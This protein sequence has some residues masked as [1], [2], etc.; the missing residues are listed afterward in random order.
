MSSWQFKTATETTAHLEHAGH[1]LPEYKA[2]ISN[3][4]IVESH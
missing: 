4:K 3:M 1:L 2:E